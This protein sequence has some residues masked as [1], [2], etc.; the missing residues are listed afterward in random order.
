MIPN[1]TETLE[2]MMKNCEISQR[3]IREIGKIEGKNEKG[4]EAA[5]VE[6]SV[7]EWKVIRHAMP[8]PHFEDE[9]IR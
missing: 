9:T 6:V 5:L 7:R 2:A 1:T 3:A 4:A 8:I